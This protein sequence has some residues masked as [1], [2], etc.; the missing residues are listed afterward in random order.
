MLYFIIKLYL[1]SL[2]VSLDIIQLFKQKTKSHRIVTIVKFLF[3]RFQQ[4][5]LK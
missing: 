4:L 1:F 5:C 2:K 3:S